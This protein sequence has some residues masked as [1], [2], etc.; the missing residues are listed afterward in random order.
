MMKKNDYIIIALGG[1]IISPAPGKIN[2]RF[3]KN[4]RELILKYLKQKRKFIIVAGGGKLSR[5]YQKSASKLANIS[6][7]DLDWLGVHS[8]HLNAHFL[9][10]I[11]LKEAYPVIFNNPEKPIIKK[12]PLIIASGWK[13]GWS[14][15]F[16]AMRLA[17][18]FNTDSVI[19]ASNISY[20]YEKDPSKHKKVKKFSE[21][22][23]QNYQKLINSHWKPG[24]NAP[25]DPL[26]AKFAKRYKIKAILFKGTELDNFKNCFEGRKI[27]GTTIT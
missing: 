4:F 25:V 22:S 7:T 23:W 1:S 14:T 19:I 9:R 12:H 21:I 18:K 8:T 11:F 16:I 26:A 24:M 15:D 27:K 13:P 2:T 3:L 17:K 20:V 10:T 5:L 6:N